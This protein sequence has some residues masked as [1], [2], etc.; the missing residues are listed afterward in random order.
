MGALLLHLAGAVLLLRGKATIFLKFSI[1]HILLKV[2]FQI[3]PV[4]FQIPYVVISPFL[5]FLVVVPVYYLARNFLEEE[6]AIE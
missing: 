3:G 5:V 2:F 4:F 1:F 6:S